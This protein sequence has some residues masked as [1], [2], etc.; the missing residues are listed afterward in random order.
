MI[1]RAVRIKA[2]GI[3]RHFSI[4][5]MTRH[6]LTHCLADRQWD[7]NVLYYFVQI[8]YAFKTEDFN[9]WNEDN[10][11]TVFQVVVRMKLRIKK[12]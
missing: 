8:T 4:D 12:T 1:K 11:G 6:R 10:A 5:I 9:M 7:L 2:I 3:G